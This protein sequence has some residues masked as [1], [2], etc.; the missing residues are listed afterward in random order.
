M[1]PGRPKRHLDDGFTLVE[2]LIVVA[3]IA[4]LLVMIVPYYGS[5]HARTLLVKCQ[6]NL[7][8]VGVGVQSYSQTHDSLPASEHVAN[9]HAELLTEMLGSYVAAEAFYCP[10]EVRSDL[11]YSKQNLQAGNISYY[12]YCCRKATPDHEASQ[13]L[14]RAGTTNV[15]WPRLITKVGVMG[16]SG[17]ETDPWVMS[18]RWVSGE[19]PHP[20]GQKGL[21]FL[22]LGGQVK[23]AGGSP[24][25]EF[26]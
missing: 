16:I 13:F 10:A 22:L 8:G 4:L 24:R 7:R 23:L 3:I 21:N 18:D 26:R 20:F 9:P 11:R 5:A 19:L 17:W 14:W 15:K 25:D 2:T 12:Y 1:T 6:W